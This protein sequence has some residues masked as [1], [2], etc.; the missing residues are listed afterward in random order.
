M[1]LF[2]FPDQTR[3]HAQK[4]DWRDHNML[5]HANG[6]FQPWQS[7]APLPLVVS[8]RQ[9]VAKFA[10][11]KIWVLTDKFF[12]SRPLAVVRNL[13]FAGLRLRA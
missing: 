11:I 1:T 4:S 3:R 2:G 7:N 10:R 12:L 13:P 6:N 9:I 5:A 8:P